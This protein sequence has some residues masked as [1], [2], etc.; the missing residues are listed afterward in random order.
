MK[1][2]LLVGLIAMAGGDAPHEQDITLIVGGFLVSGFVVTHEKYM[3]HHQTMIMSEA[4][5]KE[6]CGQELDEDAPNFIHLLDAKYFTPGQPPTPTNMNI[7]CRIALD[8][9]QGFS[10]GKLESGN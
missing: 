4:A 10:L 5:L 9:V 7:Y 2:G 3:E 8:S 6:F 1:D